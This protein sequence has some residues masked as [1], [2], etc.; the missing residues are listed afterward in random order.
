WGQNTRSPTAWK[1]S[2]S[3]DGETWEEVD[4]QSGIAWASA[5]E[6]KTFT[7]SE[8]KTY[9]QW[10]LDV[11]TPGSSNRGGIFEMELYGSLSEASTRRPLVVIVR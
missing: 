4:V 9:S 11:V 3:D 7:L 2:G 8:P 10:R 5:I 1:I 6:Q